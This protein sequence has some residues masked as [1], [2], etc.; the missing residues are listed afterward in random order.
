MVSYGLLA[1]M[2]YGGIVY[3]KVKISEV[4]N[5]ILSWR[6]FHKYT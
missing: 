3:K 1:L 2:K 5:L 6:G 4:L